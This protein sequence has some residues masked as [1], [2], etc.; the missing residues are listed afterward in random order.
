[1][2][3]KEESG[4]TVRWRNGPISDLLRSPSFGRQPLFALPTFPI[5]EY[6]QAHEKDK[7]VV[8]LLTP[9]NSPS[10]LATNRRPQ[11]TSATFK[12]VS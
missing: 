3:Q 6:P 12:E 5:R 4:Q 7:E 9:A 2:D 1:M 10:S 8:R 11:L